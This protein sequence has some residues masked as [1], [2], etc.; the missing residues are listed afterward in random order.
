MKKGFTL[1]ELSIVLVIIGLLIGG[2][3]VAQ[4]LIDSAKIQSTIKILGQSD[5]AISN[6]KD[7]Y[8]QLPGDTNLTLGAGGYT[9]DNDGIVETYTAMQMELVVI[10]PIKALDFNMKR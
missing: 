4:S 8:R 2:V 7:R 3:L 10:Q 1:V 6:F 9:G 5:I